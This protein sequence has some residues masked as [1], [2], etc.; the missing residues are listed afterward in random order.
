MISKESKHNFDV[1]ILGSG[2]SGSMIAA[3]LGK[4]GVSVLLIDG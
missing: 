4:K 3:I 2:L 1:A